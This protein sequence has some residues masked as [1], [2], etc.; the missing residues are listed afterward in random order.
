[1]DINKGILDAIKHVR[2]KQHKP[3]TLKFIFNRLVKNHDDIAIENLQK[4]IENMEKEGVLRSITSKRS[5]DPSYEIIDESIVND[6]SKKNGDTEENN[7]ENVGEL[8]GFINKYKAT[9]INTLT[10]DVINQV[11]VK[12]KETEIKDN[13]DKLISHLKEEICYLRNTLHSRDALIE[14]LIKDNKKDSNYERPEKNVKKQS[15]RNTLQNNNLQETLELKNKYSPLQVNDDNEDIE[16]HTNNISK[17]GKSGNKR[18]ICILGDSLLKD[19]EAHKI[20]EALSSNERVYVKNFSGADID[21]MK[22]YVIPTKKHENDLL[23]LHFGTNSLRGNK[24]AEDIAKEIIEIGIDMKTT[25]NE[26]MISGI[27]PRNDKLNTKGMEVND[28]LCSLCSIYN[29]YFID[30][31]KNIK[32]DKH[33]NSSG[34]HLNIGGTYTLGNNLVNA[35]RL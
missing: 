10:E 17:N 28:F 30:N 8:E 12:L 18:S 23:I 19:I 4:L 2:K 32:R 26:I 25:K 14:S 16:T 24:S 33:L 21:D 27:V 35:I 5:Q 6:T 7:I 34:L 20:R 29:F 11:L 1:M 3:S 13:Y 31:H 9:L 22:S 15:N